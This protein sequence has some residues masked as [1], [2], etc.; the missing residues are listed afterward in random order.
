MR[1]LYVAINLGIIAL[2][3]IALW[4]NKKS[5][6]YK[7]WNWRF[8][9]SFIDTA[10]VLLAATCLPALLVAWIVMWAVRP[11]T[12]RGVQLT[13]AVLLGVLFSSV[14]GFALEA[15]CVLGIFAVDLVTGQQG[16]YG[17]WKQSPPNTFMPNFAER[18]PVMAAHSERTA[19]SEVI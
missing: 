1:R 3:G 11:F 10:L 6:G 18:Q 15:L 13:L 7:S 14:G 5:Y 8:N 17:W 16:I 9:K 2:F 4:K 12:R 19:S